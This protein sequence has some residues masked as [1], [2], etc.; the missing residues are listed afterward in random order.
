VTVISPGSGAESVAEFRVTPLKPGLALWRASVDSLA[1]EITPAN[2]AR[3]VAVEVAPAK[4]GVVMLSGGLNWDFTFL[5]RAL[6]GDSS[7]AVK[8][9]IRSGNGWTAPDRAEVSI[10]G[11]EALRGEAVVVLDAMAPR[12]I[13]G[14][15]DTALKAFVANG[16]AMIAFGGPLPGVTR[17][18]SGTF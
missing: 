12:D 15:F 1:G 3:Q 5:R 11:V 17:Y 14:A 16:G 13:S 10:P 7:L 2:N 4:L 8:A 9:W 18:R 6:A